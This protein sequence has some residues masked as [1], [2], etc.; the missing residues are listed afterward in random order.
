MRSKEKV[1]EMLEKINRN[2]ENAIRNEDYGLAEHFKG[3]KFCL[4]WVLGR[5]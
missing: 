2:I 3:W 1:E 4:E 5:R